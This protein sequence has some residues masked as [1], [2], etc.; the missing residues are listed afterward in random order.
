MLMFGVLLQLKL[1]FFYYYFLLLK[2]GSN[3]SFFRQ[4][5]LINLQPIFLFAYCLIGRI[6]PK[7]L[8]NVFFLNG[9]LV[10]SISLFVLSH[11]GMIK[12]TADK[13]KATDLRAD[14]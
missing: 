5:C 7:L 11:T 8:K 10:L 3:I 13:H 4:E 2:E 12:A 9:I 1:H 14:Q 6:L